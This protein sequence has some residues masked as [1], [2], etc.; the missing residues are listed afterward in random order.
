MTL[1]SDGAYTPHLPAKLETVTPRRRLRAASSGVATL[2]CSTS[3]TSSI[4]ALIFIGPIETSKRPRIDDA[5]Y[6]RLPPQA[7]QLDQVAC[8]DAFWLPW[9]RVRVVPVGSRRMRHDGRVELL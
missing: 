3:A 6:A 8:L 5:I 7:L 2:T 1:I 9:L 4:E